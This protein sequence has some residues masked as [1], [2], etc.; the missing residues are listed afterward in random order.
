MAEGEKKSSKIGYWIAGIVL[1]A[2]TAIGIV[3]YR[4]NKKAKAAAAAA[5][6]AKQAFLNNI[7][8]LL[9]TAGISVNQDDS[10]IFNVISALPQDQLNQISTLLSKSPIADADKVQIIALIMKAVNPTGNVSSGLDFAG[11]G[12]KD[13]MIVSSKGR[14]KASDGSKQAKLYKINKG[15]VTL[16][17]RTLPDGNAIEVQGVKKILNTIYLKVFENSWVRK[18]DVEPAAK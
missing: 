9:K 4:N 14:I 12:S 6:A 16:Q 10:Q 17:N 5:L 18:T 7:V 15:V 2:G 11:D 13:E 3:T 1:A 8:Q